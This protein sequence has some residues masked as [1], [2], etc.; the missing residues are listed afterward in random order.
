MLL[1]FCLYAYLQFLQRY[2]AEAAGPSKLS[3]LSGFLRATYPRIL[4]ALLSR[5]DARARRDVTRL[6]A[7]L[8]AAQAD[9]GRAAQRAEQARMR[10]YVRVFV[11][12]C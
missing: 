7:E 12:Q 10:A 5:Q 8:T 6:T 3:A 11:S 2:D 4:S 1:A 9:A